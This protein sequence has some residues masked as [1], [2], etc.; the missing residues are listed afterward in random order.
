MKK[1]L[2]IL[3]SIWL[4]HFSV[5]SQSLDAFLIEAAQNNP[6]LKAQFY[7]YN[8]ALERVDQQNALPDPTL[9]FGYFIS[10]VETRVGAQ[11]F[12][13]SISQMFPWMGT[14]KSKE[15]VAIAEAQVEFEKFEEKKNS[16]FYQVKIVYLDLYLLEKEIL[17]KQ[18]DLEVLKSYEPIS[19]TKY[20]SNLVSL[21]DLIRVQIAIDHAV[22]ELEIMES[23]RRP[24]IAELNSIINRSL[25]DE[26]IVAEL[27]IEDY[28][29]GLQL[30]SALVSH[31]SIIRA[32]SQISAAEEKVSL[33]RKNRKPNIGIG[34]DYAFV[35]ERTDMDVVDNG[36]DIF[37]PMVSLSLPIFNKRN[38]ALEKEAMQM[39]T[40]ANQ[41]LISEQ[42]KVKSA[43]TE[44]EYSST[45]SAIESKQLEKEVEQTE[46]LLRVLLSEYSNNNSNFEELLSTQQKLLQLNLAM[47]KTEAKLFKSTFLKDYLTGQTLKELRNHE[48][49]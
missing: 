37:M 19:K 25:E 30:D 33:S 7:R 10:P 1:T 12:K 24:L 29:S 41:L 8:A 39:R 40:S 18:Q 14:L 36:K 28:Q 6:E 2:M 31:P 45:S 5:K 42:N 4:G 11:D 15:S 26:I 17:I 34:L 49:E 44:M 20:E 3:M 9:S 23:K 46:V 43:W 38:K 21:T 16:L 47:L 48:T 32:H 27:E 13:L 35:S 22:S